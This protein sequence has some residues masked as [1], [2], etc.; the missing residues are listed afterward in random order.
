MLMKP[1]WGLVFGTLCCVAAA[2]A[3]GIAYL[4]PG[5]H[6]DSGRL[7]LADGS[8]I[9]IR[10]HETSPLGELYSVDEREIVID[11]PVGE[12][13]RERLRGS[14]YAAPDVRRIHIRRLSDA[15]VASLPGSAD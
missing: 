5:S 15:A 1:L 11:Q 7:R 3:E 4:G 13:E 12:E 9:E 2:N 14:G 8:E 6:P 10:R